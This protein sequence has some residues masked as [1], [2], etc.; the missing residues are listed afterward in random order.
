MT[1]LYAAPI[2][3]DAELIGV[4]V[5]ISQA[6]EIYENLSSLRS[7]MLL[8][9]LLVAASALIISMFVVRT[10]TRP[11]GELSAGI[12][13]MSRGDLSARVEVRGQKR[14][15]PAGQRL[16]LHVRAPGKAGYVAQPVRLQ[17]L[18]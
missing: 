3:Y 18:P 11:I 15:R 6:Q 10:I 5:Y 8:W 7:Q 4:L 2:Y 13:R 17:R 9:M 14:V 12:S 16:Q 1:G